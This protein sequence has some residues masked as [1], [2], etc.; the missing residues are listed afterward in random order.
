RRGLLPW[1]RLLLP[2]ATTQDDGPVRDTT[3]GLRDQTVPA[4]HDDVADGLRGAREPLAPERPLEGELRTQER[5]P[6]AARV[7]ARARA[8]L[9]E[10]RGEVGDLRAVRD[11]AREEQVVLHEV[12]VLVAARRRDRGATVDDARVVEGVRE[13]RV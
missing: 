13:A 8:V 7:R 2:R 9:D 12:E 1:S 11:H 4:P 5:A 10:R 3:H 6:A